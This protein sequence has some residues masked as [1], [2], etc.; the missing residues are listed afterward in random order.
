MSACSPPS[1]RDNALTPAISVITISKDD[2]QGLIETVA[3]VADQTFRDHELIVIRSGSS[4]DASLPP[5]HRLIVLEDPGRGISQALNLG[6]EQASGDWVLFLNGGDVFVGR[7]ALAHLAGLRSASAK[8]IASFAEVAGR[9]FTIP[10]HPLVPGRDGF[11][12]VSHQGTLFR[13]ELFAKFGGFSPK[14]RIRMDLEWLT[15]LPRSTAYEFSGVKTIRFDATGVS[16]TRVVRSSLEE[17]TIL[18]HCPENRW[19]ALEVALMRLPFRV[20]RGV[21]RRFA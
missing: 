2:P 16:A 8:L 10:R 6:V 9:P 1:L 14:Y 11:L 18:W 19:R 21:W 17:V 3:S 12:Y 5:H 15:R 13:R 20:L 7:S 4:S